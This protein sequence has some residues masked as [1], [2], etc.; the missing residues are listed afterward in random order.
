MNR[1]IRELDCQALELGEGPYYDGRTDTAWWFDIVNKRLIEQQMSGAEKARIHDLPAMASAGARISGERQLL[2]M[3]DGL[4]IR[5]VNGGALEKTASFNGGRPDM[6]SNDGRVHP[7]GA[8]WIGT[9]SKKAEKNAGAVYWFD[10][11]SLRTLYSGLTIPNSICFSPDGAAGYFTDTKE[12]VIRRTA[13]D[14][15]TGLPKGRPEAFL[16]ADMLPRGGSFD[17]SVTDQNGVLWNAAWGSGA[18]TGFAPDGSVVEIIEFP[19]RQVTCP[20]FTGARLDSL[21]VTSA[22]ERYDAA[23]HA[24]DPGAGR[25]FAVKGGFAG[26][27]CPDFRPAQP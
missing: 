15:A 9:M 13:V 18:V 11:R 10:G 27:P 7:S 22:Y 14:P 6:R 12:G 5:S 17:G 19:A 2:A 1:Q 24:L 25:T 23:A 20:C 3:E 4:Y 8:L 21:L 16:T 26:L